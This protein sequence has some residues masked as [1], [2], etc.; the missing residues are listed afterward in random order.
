MCTCTSLVDSARW[1]HLVVST[2]CAPQARSACA[3]LPSDH[4]YALLLAVN[5]VGGGRQQRSPSG[6]I[7]SR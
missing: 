7:I 4:V 3:A 6:I 1:T 2:P 5:D